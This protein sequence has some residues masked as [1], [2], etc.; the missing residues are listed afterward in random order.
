M[1]ESIRIREMTDADVNLVRKSFV[2]EYSKA[3]GISPALASSKLEPLLG[4]WNCDVAEA[5]GVPG[6]VLG[7]ILWRD[8]STV[9]FL[10]VKPLFRHHSIAGRLLSHVGLSDRPISTPFYTP[11][12]G[13]W[14]KKYGITLRWRPY[15]PDVEA[16]EWQATVSQASAMLAASR[17]AEGE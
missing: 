16:E 6:E 8:K 9:G 2:R 1:S 15:L 17:E 11:F 13:K 12:A 10:Y 7:W 5:D 3:H 14:C 4:A